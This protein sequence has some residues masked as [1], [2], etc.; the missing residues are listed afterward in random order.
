MPESDRSGDAPIS[1]W[2]DSLKRGDEQAAAAVWNRYYT[3]LVGFAAK[4][5]RRARNRAA[6]ADDVV[7]NA[8][9]SFVQRAVD[10]RFPDLRDR[11]DL[12]KLLITITE[13]KAVNQIR[14]ENRQKRGG[15]RV[16]GDSAMVGGDPAN[17][18][19]GFD[20]L[21]GPE[22]TPEISAQVAEVVATMLG[23]LDDSLREIALRK[24]D[25]YTNAEIAAQQDCAVVTIERR[26]RLI[27]QKWN[28]MKS[29]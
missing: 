17:G 15:G 5:L 14:D 9:A 23:K 7:A 4:K 28:H 1:A 27:R 8:F 6:D 16:R 26:L 3:Q 29:A 12:W 10:G 21:A 18:D 19:G 13:R 25:G 20:R 2:I 11:D 24:L 22:P